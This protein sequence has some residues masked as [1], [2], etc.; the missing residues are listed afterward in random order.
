WGDGNWKIHDRGLYIDLILCH[1]SFL[2]KKQIVI[3]FY[4]VFMVFSCIFVISCGN[5]LTIDDLY[6]SNK[7]DLE[8]YNLLSELKPNK[9]KIREYKIDD[10]V[11]KDIRSIAVYLS[12]KDDIDG[13]MN[14]IDIYNRY[15]FRFV[16]DKDMGNISYGSKTASESHYISEEIEQMNLFFYSDIE[17]YY[18][19][20][21]QVTLH[22]QDYRK[23]FLKMLKSNIYF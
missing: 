19:Y 15:I 21:V 8:M 22:F 11:P 13:T 6:N 7:I 17:G 9:M 1:R 4:A 12:K 18:L 14:F 10:S 3:F 16:Y 2:M 5:T 23:W 20:H